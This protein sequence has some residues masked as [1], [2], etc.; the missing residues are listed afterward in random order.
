MDPNDEAVMLRRMV[1]GL[2]KDFGADLGKQHLTL[3]KT[4]SSRVT[5]SRGLINKVSKKKQKKIIPFFPTF[6]I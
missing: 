3:G 1:E 6:Y 2:R 5:R 4:G